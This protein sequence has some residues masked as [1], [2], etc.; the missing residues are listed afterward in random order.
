MPLV[1]DVV[2]FALQKH[3]DFVSKTILIEQSSKAKEGGGVVIGPTKS[4]RARLLSAP[5]S[6]MQ[7]L[8]TYRAEYTVLREETA[9]KW[10][11]ANDL[12]ENFLFTTWNGLPLP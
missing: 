6:L 10:E 9:N 8:E 5:D 7:L 3:I 2:R 4:R 12:A 1:C 11:G